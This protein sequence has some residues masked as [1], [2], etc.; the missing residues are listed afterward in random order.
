MSKGPER[1]LTHTR[2]YGVVLTSYTHRLAAGRP[3]W[4]PD[5]PGR[6]EGPCGR[7]I[8]PHVA[9][10]FPRVNL[11]HGSRQSFGRPIRPKCAARMV[12]RRHSVPDFVYQ[13]CRGNNLKITISFNRRFKASKAGFRP[14]SYLRPA[15]VRITVLSPIPADRSAGRSPDRSKA[16]HGRSKRFQ[17]R[18]GY[19]RHTDR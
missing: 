7:P 9:G 14:I 4:V 8:R 6:M 1:Y 11:R 13:Y 17:E 10:P 5:V 2:P 3:G 12:V 18:T 15:G 16:V 19:S